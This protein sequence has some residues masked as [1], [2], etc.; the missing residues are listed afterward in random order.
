MTTD[1]TRAGLLA[2]GLLAA[3]LAGCTAEP[4]AAPPAAVDHAQTVER[5][6]DTPHI[7]A[8]PIDPA[9]TAPA[10][11]S[12]S[13]AGAEAVDVTRAA[14]GSSAEVRKADPVEQSPGAEPATLSH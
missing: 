5:G 4:P 2:A 10:E 8:Q 1:T 9:A 7:P 3:T 14:D 11:A 13:G 12:A 6:A